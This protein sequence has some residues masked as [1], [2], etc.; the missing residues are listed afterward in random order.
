MRSNPALR[1]TV[2]VLVIVIVI[3]ATWLVSNRQF[4]KSYAWLNLN[5][6]YN[7]FSLKKDLEGKYKVVEAERLKILDSLELQLRLMAGRAQAG[8]KDAA[9]AYE[10]QARREDYLTKKQQFEDDNDRL[11]ADYNSQVLTQINQY[12]KDFAAE[13]GFSLVLGAD[14]TGALMFAEESTEVTDQVLLFINNKY[15]GN[16]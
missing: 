5:K 12:V 3:A 7:E 2:S 14:G 11:R 15:K 4:K 10:F 6:V 1:I 13:K 9:L 16:K 8:A